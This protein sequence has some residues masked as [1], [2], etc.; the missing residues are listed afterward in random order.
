[1]KLLSVAI[2]MPFDLVSKTIEHKMRYPSTGVKIVLRIHPQHSRN[3][4]RSPF[5]LI[6]QLEW[7]ERAD[8]MAA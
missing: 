3:D 5:V 1:M 4:S 6:P 8:T 2:Y 7:R